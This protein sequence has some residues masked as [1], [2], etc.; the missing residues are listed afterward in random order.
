MID[1][2]GLNKHRLET[3]EEILNMLKEHNKVAIVRPTGYGKSHLIAELC[4][5][6]PGKKLIL[7]PGKEIINYMEKFNIEMT[8]TNYI[9]YHSLLKPDMIE[10]IKDFE[11][12]DYIFLDEMH[13]ALAEKWGNKL[14]NIFDALSKLNNK[15]KILGFSATPIR[16]DNK[17]VIEEMFNGV[18]IEPY[19]L[20]DAIL[21]NFLPIPDYHCGI[22]EIEDN[23]KKKMVLKDE[24]LAKQILEYDIDAS[25]SKM[26]RDNLDFSKEHKIICFVDKISNIKHAYNNIIKWF[27]I[28]I[29]V[30]EVNHNQSKSKTQKIIDE[31]VSTK[32]INILFCVNILNEG[33][34]LPNV[35]CV[36]FLRKTKSNVIYNQQLGRV[37]NT[38]IKNPIIFDLVNNA[39]NPEWGYVTMFEEKA[40]E[41]N[42]KVID[43]ET[44]NKDKLKITLEQIDLI[45]KLKK[46]EN[47]YSFVITDEIKEWLKENSNK[48][49][50]H[51]IKEN[52]KNIFGKDI[53]E[54]TLI[55]CIKN[56]GLDYNKIIGKVDYEYIKNYIL[57]NS[58]KTISE[59]AK[60]L[61]ENYYTIKYI[62]NKYNITCNNNFSKEHE[63]K[64]VK[65]NYKN[66]TITN[67]SRE[68]NRSKGFISK[69]IKNE[70]LD[71]YNYH[72]SS[73]KKY[74]DFTNI[75]KEFIKDIIEK[76]EF[77]NITKIY[78]KFINK[79]GN[80]CS[81][82][83]FKNY[84]K[85]NNIIKIEKRD[86]YNERLEWLKEN[87]KNYNIN[88]SAK[89]LH[90]SP[91]TIRR[92]CYEN[93]IEFKKYQI[94]NYL[95]EYDMNFIL[96]NYSNQT[97]SEMVYNL[98]SYTIDDKEYFSKNRLIREYC[99]RKNLDYKK[100]S[101][102]CTTQIATKVMTRRKQN[103][104]EQ[105]SKELLYDLYII[106]NYTYKETI[107]I[108]RNEYNIKISD[109]N[110]RK[111]VKELGIIKPNSLIKLNAW[112]TRKSN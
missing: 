1:Y 45:E 95:T 27:G 81:I 70:N 19:Y 50:I 44:K 9:T 63:I 73:N 66:K 88:E 62:C 75:Q 40:E 43:L 23:D 77:I 89:I 94:V 18:Q 90:A 84:I 49:N 57:R 46:L 68:L 82:Y 29:N 2:E 100:E 80:I 78:N 16:G 69:I 76:E 12:Y 13:R 92:M 106:K 34:H 3:K 5:E 26:F 96:N 51:E 39:D 42:K 37:I 97:I 20:A 109:K 4:N 56:N 28:N 104:R 55:G 6:L 15:V 33:V 17:D 98:Y 38:E 79:F 47:I 35:D 102:K 41:Q 99:V 65:N 58:D 30:F 108:L 74:S 53:C 112:K 91:K 36:I 8:D 7:E 14:F 24:Q 111:R 52:I 86:K 105:I 101:Q 83:I 107:E 11:Q 64:Y 22:Y 59:I 60:E 71:Y 31:F 85:K 72:N 48:Y 25:L 103:I 10:L 61:N 21:D 93:N 54:S 87:S 110:L 32:G 67:M